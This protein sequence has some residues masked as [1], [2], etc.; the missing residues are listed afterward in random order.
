MFHG[1][2]IG[3]TGLVSDQFNTANCQDLPEGS[4]EADGQKI[5][6]KSSAF[7]LADPSP[8]LSFN[9]PARLAD[10]EEPSLG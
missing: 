1:P 2:V 8:S 4:M 6:D 5:Q 3:I 9:L 7:L 10:D